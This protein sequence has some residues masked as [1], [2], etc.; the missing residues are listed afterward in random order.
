MGVVF[1]KGKGACRGK[2]KIGSGGK[3]NRTLIS[4]TQQERSALLV[5]EDASLASAAFHRRGKIATRQFVRKNGKSNRRHTEK[6]GRGR[7]D[8]LTSWKSCTGR[9][10]KS[11]YELE[12]EK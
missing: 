6:N 5:R 12:P 2:K 9:S 11:W 7:V 10:M 3:G 4:V 1:Y 8:Q